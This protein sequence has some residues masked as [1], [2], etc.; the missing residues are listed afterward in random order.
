MNS[1]LRVFEGL[2]SEAGKEEAVVLAAA[3]VAVAATGATAAAGALLGAVTAGEE[4]TGFTAVATA[5][6]GCV[7]ISMRNRAHT[8]RWHTK[9]EGALESD[10]G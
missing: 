5:A 10:R 9:L 8:V 3:G 2:I 1:T 6:A 4:G 7:A